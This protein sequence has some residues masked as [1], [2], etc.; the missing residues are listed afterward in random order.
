MTSKTFAQ[1]SAKARAA[2]TTVD[3]EFIPNAEKHIFI[4]RALKLALE[5][6]VIT[7]D[8]VHHEINNILVAV[9]MPASCAL[10]LARGYV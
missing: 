1:D 6:Q 10:R 3:D 2:Q 9:R 7:L 4:D 8:D 5:D